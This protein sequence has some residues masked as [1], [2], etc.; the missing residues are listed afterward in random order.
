MFVGV[1]ICI[2]IVPF[3]CFRAAWEFC[4][5]PATSFQRKWTPIA[6]CGP[7]LFLAHFVPLGIGIMNFSVYVDYI[8]DDNDGVREYNKGDA[9]FVILVE[10]GLL[11]SAGHFVALMD[12]LNANVFGAKHAC[13]KLGGFVTKAL[14]PQPSDLP[15][16]EAEQCERGEPCEP[17]QFDKHVVN[18]GTAELNRT[19]SPI[20]SQRLPALMVNSAAA[21]PNV[22]HVAGLASVEQS[23]MAGDTHLP[24]EVLEG[25]DASN[26]QY[27]PTDSQ[28][29]YAAMVATST[30]HLSAVDPESIGNTSELP[31]EVI[32]NA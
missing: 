8:V 21:C 5:P 10:L 1:I 18:N 9:W 30:D 15:S 19:T 28:N 29:T 23:S 13:D 27:T 6:I 2:G 11:V 24:I 3:L 25:N 26:K 32:E 12:Q 17:A 16:R 14:H 7:F 4:L 31:G 20:N 22:D